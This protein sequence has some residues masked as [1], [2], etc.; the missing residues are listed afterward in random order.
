[1]NKLI[2]EALKGLQN[3]IYKLVICENDFTEI[4]K[5]MVKHYPARYKLELGYD[6][7]HFSLDIYQ[8][9]DLKSEIRDALRILGRLGYRK[10]VDIEMSGDYEFI[11]GKLVKEGSLPITIYFYLTSDSAYKKVQTGTKEVP[12][13]E[14][15]CEEVK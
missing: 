13:Y 6:L 4:K 3:K 9:K 14:I 8:V 1:M 12:V 5:L 15:Q 2:K 7:E 11:T 10:S